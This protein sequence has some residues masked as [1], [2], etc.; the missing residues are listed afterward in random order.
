MSRMKLNKNNRRKGALERR[1]AN[2]ENY[3]GKVKGA[4]DAATKEFYTDKLN[5]AKADVKALQGKVV[6]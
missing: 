2:V 6:N 1:Q 3:E 4:S 5:K